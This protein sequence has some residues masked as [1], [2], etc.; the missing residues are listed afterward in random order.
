[1]AGLLGG[2]G[3]SGSGCA[4]KAKCRDKTI[5]SAT[6]FSLAQ[7]NELAA[8]VGVGDCVALDADTG[9]A[10]N[11]TPDFCPKYCGNIVVREVC[12]TK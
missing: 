5:T 9:K 7:I 10:L 1:M 12:N 2:A 3:S 6:G 8:S 11:P 4:Y